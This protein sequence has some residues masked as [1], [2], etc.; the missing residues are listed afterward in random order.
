MSGASNT[1]G[2][3]SGD[4][5]P[6]FSS[7]PVNRMSRATFL[8]RFFERAFAGSNTET[9]PRARRPWRLIAPWT[10]LALGSSSAGA[11]HIGSRAGAAARARFA[12]RR[13]SKVITVTDALY[14]ARCSRCDYGVK[15]RIRR[16]QP[17]SN[18]RRTAARNPVTVSAAEWSRRGLTPI[19]VR[20]GKP[21]FT[22]V[23]LDGIPLNDITN[24]LGGSFYLRGMSPDNIEQVEIVRGPPSSVYGDRP[25][26]SG[27]H[28]LIWPGTFKARP[29]RDTPHWIG[30]AHAS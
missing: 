5:S 2:R 23:M 12:R 22:L 27:R 6:R 28:P 21:N 25:L 24:I 1:S 17:R 16:T 20:A 13:D 7:T 15:S 11:R 18:R 3:S 10:I 4:S 29:N 19:P 30:A 9:A 14:T 8:L 26:P